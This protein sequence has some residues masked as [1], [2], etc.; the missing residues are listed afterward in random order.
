MVAVFVKVVPCGVAGG[1]WPTKVK[2]ALDPLGNEARVQV[3]VPF[4]PTAGWLLQ[5]NAG[6]EFCIAETKVIPGGSGSLRETVAAASVP[7]LKTVTS[8]DTAGPF[9]ALD[10]TLF[11]AAR[12]AGFSKAEGAQ[13]APA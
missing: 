3:I 8:K 10:G 5:S 11:P 4:V 9:A 7:K 2:S 13:P 6:P 1:M 12:A